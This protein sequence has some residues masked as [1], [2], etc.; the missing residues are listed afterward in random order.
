[1]SEQKA[2]PFIIGI[3][4][5]GIVYNIYFYRESIK[6][7]KVA[8]QNFVVEKQYCGSRKNNSIEIR[9]KENLYKVRVGSKECSKYPVGA[10]IKLVYN[11]KYDYFYKQD[12]LVTARY[13]LFFFSI[14]LLVY[15][16][17]WKR[18]FKKNS[19]H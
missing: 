19:L 13:R 15:I 11:D 5:I 10:E 4:A 8:S 14:T 18:I 1:M 9:Y 7:E 16:I 2:R 17:P 6:M 3:L 12:G